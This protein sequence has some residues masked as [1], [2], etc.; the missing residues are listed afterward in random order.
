MINTD[1]KTAA[2]QIIDSLKESKS[3]DDRKKCIPLLQEYLQSHPDDAVAWYALAGCFD[4][5]GSETE[6]EPCYKRTFDLGHNKLPENEQ[7]GFFVGYGST[8]RN[9]FK[10]SES[11]EVLQKSIEAF[12]NYPALN[13]FLAFTL[14]T[15]GKF[16]EAAEKLFAAITKIEGKPFDG[17]ERAIKWYVDNLE[18]HPESPGPQVI[19]TPRMIL[20]PLVDS[21][22]ESV[23]EYCSDPEV[24]KFTT[25]SP[26]RTLDDSQLLISYAKKNYQRNIPEPY[27][28]TLK[29][30]PQKVIG[31]IGWFWVSE[32]HKNIEIAYALA[33]DLWGQ[34]LIF[35]ASKAVL[36]L[37][38]K[39]HDIHR[40]SSRCIAEN[41][42]SARVLEKLGM[43]YE[44]TQRQV[45]YIKGQ[46][47]DLKLYAILRSEWKT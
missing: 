4:F 16:R 25:W 41:S 19:E 18:N 14:Y 47:V 3:E 26:H 20:R 30:N 28:I 8:L 44:G 5:I 7:T 45:M 40:I 43:T 12:P 27:A 21:D 23:F 13:V 9:N 1:A 11:K 46:F 38:I 10:F 36:D 29:S 2:K 17:Y 31:T 39:N 33:K 42:G 6:A 37:A 35:E 15:Q 34:G 24:S 32:L 22:V